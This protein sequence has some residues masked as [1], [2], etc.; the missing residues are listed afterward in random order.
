[1]KCFDCEEYEAEFVLVEYEQV[2]PLCKGCLD[3]HINIEG[4]MNLSYFHI[5]ELE[6]IFNEINAILKYDCDVY[7]RLLKEYLTLKKE[8]KG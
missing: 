1:M 8:A 7:E 6:L 3:G 5:S 4:D 2:L